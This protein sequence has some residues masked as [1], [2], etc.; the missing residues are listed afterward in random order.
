M[1]KRRKAAN[2]IFSKPLTH[3]GD[4]FNRDGKIL[5]QTPI[6]RPITCSKCGVVGGTLLKDS[7]GDYYHQNTT[8][9]NILRLRK[10]LIEGK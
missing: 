1:T 3:N 6:G 9:C 8:S 4:M 5:T 7:E 10:P 2:P